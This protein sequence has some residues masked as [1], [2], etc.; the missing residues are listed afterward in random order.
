MKLFLLQDLNLTKRFKGK[1]LEEID[2]QGI[3]LII[4]IMCKS[5]SL[6]VPPTPILA[7]KIVRDLLSMIRVGE[8]KK[9]KVA[10]S[11]T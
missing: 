1:T 6:L 11:L 5:I 8:I 2:L 9:L 10:K 3:S 4:F 7:L